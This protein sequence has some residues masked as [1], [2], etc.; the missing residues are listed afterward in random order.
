MPSFQKLSSIQAFTFASPTLPANRI[1]TTRRLSRRGSW[2][3]IS[4]PKRGNILLAT[5]QRLGVMPSFSRPGVSNDNPYSESLFKTLKYSPGYPRQFSSVADARSWVQN[6]VCWYNEAH[7]HSGIN[8]VTPDQRHLGLDKEILAERHKTYIAARLKNPQRWSRNTRN[9][10]WE[11][12][13]YLNPEKND[14]TMDKAAWL[15]KR[16]QVMEGTTTLRQGGL[17]QAVDLIAQLSGEI[18][19]EDILGRIFSRFCIGK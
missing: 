10:A 2:T 19:N 16:I 11:E 9:W 5:L 4:F 12:K 13:V 18:T 8:Y 17:Q 14:L 3:P 7:M 15:N 1:F 6:F